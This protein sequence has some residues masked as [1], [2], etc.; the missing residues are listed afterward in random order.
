MLDKLIKTAVG[1]TLTVGMFVFEV[2]GGFVL[3]DEGQKSG[4]EKCW[5]YTKKQASKILED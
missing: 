5:D 1:A 2:S 4:T 3:T